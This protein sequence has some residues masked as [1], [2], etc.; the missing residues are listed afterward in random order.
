MDGQL[1]RITRLA[2]ARARSLLGVLTILLP[3]C[4]LGG[5]DRYSVDRTTPAMRILV[6]SNSR[7]DDKTLSSALR[8]AEV[9]FHDAGVR[10]T[11]I[12]C[13]GDA[14]PVYP[15]ECRSDDVRTLFLRIVRQPPR[16]YLGRDAMGVALTAGQESTYATVFH[17]RVLAMVP[18]SKPGL[19]GM[20]LGHVIAHE[21]GHLL[22]GTTAHASFGL[23]AAALS[24]AQLERAPC[25]LLEFSPAEAA[26][27]R[28]EVLRR[29]NERRLASVANP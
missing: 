19:E 23:M 18:R 8:K 29:S 14:Q 7:V 25:G 13:P 22:L 26:T 1:F 27:I 6:I 9:I 3:A 2:T 21:L 5:G 16:G 10:V 4:A 15:P 17:D 28:A 11:W 24:S 12:R 20:I